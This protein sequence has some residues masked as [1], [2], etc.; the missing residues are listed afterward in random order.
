MKSQICIV[1]SVYVLVA[2]VKKMSQPRRLALHIATV[3]SLTPFEE[4]FI[5]QEF[6]VLNQIKR[7]DMLVE[8]ANIR[9]VPALVVDDRYL[10]GGPNIKDNTA[11]LAIADKLIEKVRVERR[12]KK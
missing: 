8:N 1:V 9:G 11:L 7:S 12:L 3:F 5:Q 4:M 2:I 6:G 10:I